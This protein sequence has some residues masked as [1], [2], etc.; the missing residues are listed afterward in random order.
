[1][2]TEKDRA[3]IKNKGL[4]VA[5]IERQISVF[6][7]GIDF[8]ELIKPATPGE[9]I[10]ELDRT[11]QKA[12][13]DRYENSMEDKPAIK[14]V[15]ASGAASRMFK[16]LFNAMEEIPKHGNKIIYDNAKLENFFS[17]L[18]EY[19]FYEDLKTLVKQDGD[20]FKML[21]EK[22]EYQ[23]I[24]E[25]LLT[26]KGLN[27]SSL[28]KGLLKF[29]LYPEGSRTALEEHYE[30][31]SMY[32]TDTKA[33]VNLHFTVSPEHLT[34][35]TSLTDVLNEKYRNS[36]GLIFNLSFSVQ[37][38]STDTI[39][40][41]MDNKPFRLEDNSI[42]FRPGGHG[43]LLDNLNDLEEP[44]VFISNI[45]N[46]CPDHSKDL[47][48]YYKKILGGF[49]VKKTESIHNILNRIEKGERGGAL[50]THILEVVS[51]ISP[52]ASEELK[53]LQNDLF[54]E[55][56]YEFL[57]K[58]V[59]VCG[60]V[61]NVGEPGGGPFWIRDE[62]GKMSK[63]IIES[64]QIDMNDNSQKEIFHSSTHF[65]P[66]DIVCYIRD[67]KG[68]KF[69]LNKFTDPSMAF[70]SKKTSGGKELKALE[71]PGLWN[72]SMA[73][74]LTWFIDV[75]LETFTPVKTIFDLLRDEHRS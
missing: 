12:M 72:G 42:L 32:L 29:H 30:E 21:L 69:D 6:E 4:S 33:A 1:M 3:E 38:P 17:Q 59:R 34:L 14:F 63:Q 61:K 67:H 16:E 31:A 62:A 22:E 27:Y 18:S 8:V 49:L 64:S 5:E 65:N 47:K 36:Q 23:K 75:P 35:F 74:W 43:A 10:E 52:E 13:I 60:M 71:H 45:D 68:E 46:V 57:N 24:L 70:I 15:P 55:Q 44:V 28:P 26:D 53:K 58:P 56:A 73:G 37:K 48:I 51:E 41:D 2:L 9:G 66:V 7:R 50:R 40:V 20:N 54:N 19:P 25:Y 39:A 11:E